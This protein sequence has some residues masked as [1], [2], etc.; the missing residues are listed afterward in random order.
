MGIVEIRKM[1]ASDM[2]AIM[3]IKNAEKWNQTE[4]DWQFLMAS[5]PGLCLVAVIKNHVVGTV[6]AI[7]YQNK[8]T[9][10]GM[11]L[12]A[13]TFRGRGISKLLLNFIINLLKDCDSIKLDAT[14]AGIPVYEKLGFVGEYKITRMVSQN[15]GYLKEPEDNEL[16]VSQITGS[17][18]S[19][20]ATMDKPIFG[21]NRFNLFQFLFSNQEHTAFKIKTGRKLKGYAFSRKGSNYTQ[22]GPVTAN[23]TQSAKQLLRNTFEKLKENP[24]VVDV[25]LDKSELI[26][27][28]VSIG[29]THQRSFTRMSLNSNKY[30]GKIENQFLISGP[31]LG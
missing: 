1:Q 18:I 8:I 15:L 23:R 20:I 11:M 7:N 22:V 16:A 27:W 13:K 30:Q 29:F 21:A 24:I 25:L 10:V 28:L 31:E 3:Q 17:D 4:A 19:S 9:W 14:P 12:V 2:E 6:T 26:D 5:N